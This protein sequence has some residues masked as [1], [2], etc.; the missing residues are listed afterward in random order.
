[1]GMLAQTQSPSVQSGVTFNWED[2]Q[3]I[4]DNGDISN[5]ENNLPATIESIQIGATLYNTF[6]V[7]SNYQLT[8]L[9]PEGHDDNGIRQNGMD[10]IGTSITATLDITDNNAWD[11]AAI[12]AFQDRN[13][14]HYFT[15]SDNGANFCAPIDFDAAATTNAQKQTIFYNPAIPSNADG[16]L[17]VTERG[18]NNC[19]YVEVYGVPQGGGPE[20]KLGETFVRTGG[21]LQGGAFNPPTPGSDYWES[22]REIDNGQS[23]AIA[24]F[25]L[26]NLAPVGSLI[27]RIEFVGASQ[28]HGDGKFFL[29][30]TYALDQTQI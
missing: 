23:V 13:L 12:R 30:Q 2:I 10:V 19:F 15:S 28:D 27:S 17:A 16:V 8:R 3:D 20:Q 1:M 18:G 29:L 26:D 4:N 9:G 21:N 11:S 6:V 5:G 7:P 25:T 14:N 24:L 22:G